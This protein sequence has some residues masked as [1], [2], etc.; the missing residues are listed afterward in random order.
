MVIKIERILCPLDLSEDSAE[1]LRYAVALTKTYGATLYLCH[2][3]D[4]LEL[5]VDINREMLGCEM[6]DQ[7][8]EHCGI[9]NFASIACETIIIDGDPV[10]A[11][12]RL[13]SDKDIDLI[14]M[15][16]RR[17]NRAG[18]LLGST[19]ESVSH[20]VGCPVLI[21][22]PG[23]RE[24]VGKTNSQIDLRRILIAHDFS[25]ESE[26]AV[27]FGLSL[28]QE[29]QAQLHLLHVL[30][31]AR[32]PKVS[33][34]TAGE[35]AAFQDAALRLYQAV[36]P[37]VSLWCDVKQAIRAGRPHE[38]ILDYAE[39]HDIDLICIGAQGAGFLRRAVFGSNADRVLRQAPC[40][41]LVVRPLGRSSV[42]QAT[43]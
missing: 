22:R 11:I 17:R 10:E 31:Y 6:R 29:Y 23:E 13:T 18:A 21:T 9:M 32:E 14:V 7:A 28:A 3:A 8:R 16:S 41:V 25:K 35:T 2:C 5:S 27:N 39:T 33:E 40:P 26:L 20:N 4:S 19:A 36:P 43:A 1:A 38:E 12:A 30:P 15:A 24:W 34:M 37:E 42:K